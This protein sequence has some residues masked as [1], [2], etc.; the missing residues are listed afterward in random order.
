MTHE[1]EEKLVAKIFDKAEGAALALV[2]WFLAMLAPICAAKA[3]YNLIT[4]DNIFMA[5]L[6][7]L[8]SATMWKALKYLNSL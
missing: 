8:F 1:E 7:L 6:L 4:L 3:T 2:K 5:W